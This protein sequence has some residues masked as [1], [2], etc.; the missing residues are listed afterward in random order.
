[1]RNPL[2]LLVNAISI[3]ALSLTPAFSVAGPG[4]KS[5]VFETTV[6]EADTLTP[7]ADFRFRYEA[8]WDSVNSAGIPRDERHRLRIRQRVGI[9]YH[10]DDV[11]TFDVRVRIGDP[12]SQQSPHLTIHDFTGGDRNG[13]GAVLDKYYYQRDDGDTKFWAG[14]NQ[15]P[16]WKQN[17]L[18]WDDDATITE[19]RGAV[20]ESRI[21][22]RTVGG[23]RGWAM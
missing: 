20:L 6:D 12:H 2:P 1:M 9:K 22:A 17:E 7:Y 10:P 8:D 23:V 5:T 21:G 4:E 19:V 15:Y 18:F 16:F 3:G 11:H 13:P 14:R